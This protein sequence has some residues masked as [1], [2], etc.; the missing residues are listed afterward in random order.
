MSRTL[1]LERRLRIFKWN[2][3]EKIATHPRL[4]F[5]TGVK[6]QSPQGRLIMSRETLDCNLRAPSG[7][8]ASHSHGTRM[9]CLGRC[10]RFETRKS[11]QHR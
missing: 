9:F 1:F 5:V 4:Q 7:E 2:Y 3:P 8:R 10:R 11:L 6:Y